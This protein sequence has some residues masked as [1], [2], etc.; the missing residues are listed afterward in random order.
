MK[1]M[2]THITCSTRKQTHFQIMFKKTAMPTRF[3]PKSLPFHAVP[4][5]PLGLFLNSFGTYLLFFSNY[6]LIGIST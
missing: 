1:A 4:N 6:E 5:E 2:L 3:V